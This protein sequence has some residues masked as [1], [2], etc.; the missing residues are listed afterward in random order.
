MKTK[1]LLLAASLYA[2]IA[3]S[4]Q[5]QNYY[6]GEYDATTGAIIAGFTSPSGLFN[7]RNLAVSGNNLYVSD[8]VNNTV[9]AYNATTGATIAS[10]TT[11]SGLYR[12]FGLA[13]S[14]NNLYV[15]NYNGTVGEYDATTGA[16]INA[17][18]ITGLTEPWNLGIS[19]NNLYVS[20][21]CASTRCPQYWGVLR[22]EARS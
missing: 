7:P 11:V 16:V 20:N 13:V 21:C 14:G 6:V 15:A 12:P 19:G 22:M 9:S 18:L 3:T 10:F 2:L 4:A 17:N 8:T 1:H 5:A